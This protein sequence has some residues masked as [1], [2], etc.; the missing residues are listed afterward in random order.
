MKGRVELQ[1]SGK[2]AA[3]LHVRELETIG[4][5]TRTTATTTATATRCGALQ[6][7]LLLRGGSSGGGGGSDDAQRRRRRRLRRRYRR[8]NRRS[9]GRRR[10]RG[11]QAVVMDDDVVET[12][13]EHE[14]LPARRRR[15]RGRRSRRRRGR[16]RAVVVV[17]SCRGRGLD[18]AAG[19]CCY[20]A[21]DVRLLMLVYLLLALTIGDAQLVVADEVALEVQRGLELLAT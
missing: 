5:I 20:A 6:A 4:S 8:D 19:R 16:R 12:L 3:R 10:R 18:A 7:Q 15:R 11:H 14:F 2:A 9:C 17:R 21:A 1:H 13:T